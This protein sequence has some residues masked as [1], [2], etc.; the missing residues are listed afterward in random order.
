[1]IKTLTIVDPHAR[2][3]SRKTSCVART[4]YFV[5]N[6]ARCYLSLQAGKLAALF[7]YETTLDKKKK[8][9]SSCKT[10]VFVF[11]SLVKSEAC[12]PTHCEPC[13]THHSC[14]QGVLPSRSQ[15]FVTLLW[16]NAARFCCSTVKARSRMQKCAV[17]AHHKRVTHSLGQVSK[18]LN[19]RS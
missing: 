14:F 19:L 1:M 18:G 7:Q 8:K 6:R 13:Q 9:K 5:L 15:W 3:K 17:A 4:V 12:S 11:L 16:G 2:L 10:E